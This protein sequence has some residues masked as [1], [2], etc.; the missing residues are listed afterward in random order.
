MN[1]PARTTNT[2]EKS[3]GDY[4]GYTTAMYYE[5]LQNM[6]LAERQIYGDEAKAAEYE[7]A[8]CRD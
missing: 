1:W 8:G 5:A 7:N 3:R 6:A 2:G 4:N